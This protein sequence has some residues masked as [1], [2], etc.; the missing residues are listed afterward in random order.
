MFYVA[1]K[2]TLLCCRRDVRSP[3]YTP[4]VLGC[5]LVVEA[6][7]SVLVLCRLRRCLRAERRLRLCNVYE[8]RMPNIMRPIPI[9]NNTTLFDSFL[10]L[11]CKVRANVSD[12]LS[13]FAATMMRYHGQMILTFRLVSTSLFL[14]ASTPNVF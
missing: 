7:S 8:M 2:G 4:I 5:V 3:W 10:S 13:E 11:K 9:E 6:E 14:S 12:N 1:Y